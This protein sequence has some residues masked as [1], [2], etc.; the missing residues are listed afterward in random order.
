MVGYSSHLT[1]FPNRLHIVHESS[2]RLNVAQISIRSALLT[3]QSD[4]VCEQH[5]FEVHLLCFGN[6]ELIK[7]LLHASTARQHLLV[8]IIGP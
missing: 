5:H 7:Q 8:E 2:P 6:E 4:T 1:H 3:K